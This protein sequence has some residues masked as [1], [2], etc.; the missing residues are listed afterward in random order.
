MHV[1]C[2]MHALV[3]SC[4]RLRLETFGPSLSPQAYVHSVHPRHGEQRP[5]TCKRSL[6]RARMRC[7]RLFTATLHLTVCLFLE[8]RQPVIK[9]CCDTTGMI[10]LHWPRCTNYPD[11]RALRVCI[12]ARVHGRMPPHPRGLC[13]IA[14]IH[15]P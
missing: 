6:K 3:C 11:Y 9:K 4:S 8:F 14:S 2:F 5:Q 7:W 12:C 10:C 15:A 1:C 13:F